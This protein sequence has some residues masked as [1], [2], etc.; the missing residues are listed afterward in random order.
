MKK[1]TSSLTLFFIL[2]FDVS[3]YTQIVINEVS[4]A[5]YSKFLDEDGS[6]EDW[7]ELYN[8]SSVIINLKNYEITRDENGNIKS[9]TFPNILIKG[10]SYLTIFCS[11]K[12]RTDWFDHWEVPVYANN[13]WKYFIGTSEP[14]PTWRDITFN[15]ASWQSG[16]GG[17]GYGDGDDSTIISPISSLYM[18]KT[19]T[20]ADTSKIAIGALLIDYDDAFVA[21]L[22]NVEIARSNIGIYGDHPA[23]NKL[24]Y[25]EHE[26]QMYQNGNFSGGYWIPANVIDSVLK[27][28]LNVFSIQTHNFVDGMDDLSCIPYLLIGVSDTTVTYFPFPATVHLHTD[29][30][31][32]N[33]GQIL[34]LKNPAGNIVDQQTIGYLEM[35]HSRGRIPDGSNNWCILNKPTPDSTNNLVYCYYGYENPPSFN[36]SSGFYQGTQSVSISGNSSSTIH[37]TKDGSIP[38]LGSPIYTSAVSVP[39]SRVMRARNF[40]VNANML[41][42]SIITNTY[43]INENISLPVVSLSTNSD[44][45]FDWNY[46]IYVLGPNA[47]ISSPPFFGANFWQ[48]WSRPAHIEFFDNN[49]QQAFE[50]DAEI[51][52]QGN[53]SKTFPQRGFSI[54][55][56]DD[57]GGY[58]ISYR[59]FPDKPVT[60]F[61]SFNI[62]AAG[63]DWNKC[64]MRDRLNQKNVQQFTH[65]D[66]MD[67]RPCVLFIN[68][69][70]WGVYELREKQD[71]FYIANNNN[72]DQD[73]IDFLEFDGS[74]IEGSN[75]GFLNM[76]NYIG[77][78]N[79]AI[80][81]NYDSVQKM[82]DIENFADYFIV[83]TYIINVDWLGD[84]TNNIKYWRTNNPVGKWRY[85]L[86]D[87]DISLGRSNDT[88]N[89]LKRAINPPTS[90]PHSVMLK[91]LL[92]NTEFKNYFVNRYCDLINTIYLP[93]KFRKKADDLHDEM[94]PEMARHFVLWGNFDSLPSPWNTYYPYSGLAPDVPYWEA[95]IDTM[96]MFM[97]N[98]PFYALNQI[99]SQFSLIKQVDITLDVLPVGAGEI[100]LNTISPDSLPWTGT[101]FDGVPITMTVTP[102][103]GYKFLY[104]KSPIII[105]TPIANNSLTINVTN[106][107]SF[108]A[109]FQKI[110]FTFDIFPNPC[111]DNFNI[112]YEIPEETQISLKVFDVVGKEVIDLIS[113][114]NFQP[115]GI[116]TLNVDTRKYSLSDGIYFIKFSTSDFSKIVKIVKTKQ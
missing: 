34:T 109:Y 66:I 77:A 50:L 10:N 40:S 59:L 116:Y 53:W 85:M 36:L 113:N 25:K 101:Y 11:E 92:N 30:N 91:S 52:M 31:L 54:K 43:F 72:V 8:T 23:F 32:T 16:I 57:Y 33:T 20:I 68:G 22:N 69:T 79:M 29:F 5:T 26:A 15:D 96:K 102:N 98:R 108:T 107:D 105:Q 94:L 12:N 2:L 3:S 4:S 75:K 65:I 48:D 100:Q 112:T 60:V 111:I 18:R 73:K 80:Q 35:N 87:T 103:P 83:E 58:P 56:K 38:T 27:P 44:Y 17:I 70:Y 42:S 1:I 39:S 63:S 104:W 55:A 28:G 95:N 64:H 93:Y 81:A 61:K 14:P 78:N 110:N 67:G 7:F 90:N 86:W 82:L 89:M 6:Q 97:S 84:Y 49:D 114:N 19:F 74:I 45:L 13:M 24:G 106:N 88:T 99:Q 21:Y 62:R 51:K 76:V 115:A 71:K 41:P 46:G 47:D 37:W 9:W